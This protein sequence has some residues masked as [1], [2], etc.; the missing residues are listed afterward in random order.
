[1]K[2]EMC[3]VTIVL[4]P[5]FLFSSFFFFLVLLSCSCPFFPSLARSL[6]LFLERASYYFLKRSFIARGEEELLFDY[7]RQQQE[8]KRGQLQGKNRWS[9]E[10]FNKV[11]RH[12][13]KEREREKIS[14]L[15]IYTFLLEIN[16]SFDVES[17]AK[18]IGFEYGL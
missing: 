15:D 14:L 12:S 3:S 1:M 2:I 16:S 8:E 13:L 10:H 11:H 6:S 4:F 7:L 9:L 18:Y 5:S 17:N